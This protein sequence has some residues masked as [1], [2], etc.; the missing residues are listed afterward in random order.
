MK[1]KDDILK[2]LLL[3]GAMS[4]TQLSKMLGISAS[5]VCEV[6]GQ[7]AK[8]GL[9]VRSGYSRSS[10]KGRKSVLF[11]VDV[12]YKFA[13]GIGIGDGTVCVGI[14][15]IKGRTLSH[16]TARFSE[17]QTT[18][19]IFKIIESMVKEVESDCRICKDKLIGAGVFAPS[20]LLKC[21]GFTSE[22]ENLFGVS[23]LFEPSDDYIEYSKA[24]IPINPEELYIFGCAK[25]IR[26]LFLSPKK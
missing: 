11:D 3:N 26:E 12:S 20:E 14:T 9:I 21:A 24:Y 22:A 19:G 7:L 18:D 1:A 4:Q 23:L 25:V 8:S 5:Y 15:D 17:S 2:A 6:C 13:L 10:G 16:R